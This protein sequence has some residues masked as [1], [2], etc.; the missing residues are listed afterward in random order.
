MSAT[1]N[2]TVMTERDPQAESCQR[3]GPSQATGGAPPAPPS[4]FYFGPIESENN[5][6]APVSVFSPDNQGREKKRKKKRKESESELFSSG[7]RKSHLE[8]HSVRGNSGAGCNT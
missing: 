8:A 1:V 5:E 2:T 4:P 7:R 3:G 6:P